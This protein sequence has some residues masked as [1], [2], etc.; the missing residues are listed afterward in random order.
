MRLSRLLASSIA[1]ASLGS[2]TSSLAQP[3]PAPSPTAPAAP[4]SAAPAAP[5]ASAP[6]APAPPAPAAPAAPAVTPPRLVE[7]A[8]AAYPEEA[9]KAGLE[10]AP[11]LLLDIDAEGKVTA[12]QVVE[13]AGHGFDEASREAALRFRFEPAR[14][15]AQPIRSRIRFRHVFVLPAAPGA[16]T[17]PIPAAGG[18]RRPDAPARGKWSGKVALHGGDEPL[19]GARVEARL[20]DGTVREARTGEDGLFRLE[21]LPAGPLAL[22]IVAPGFGEVEAQEQVQGGEAVEVVYRLRAP[23]PSGEVVV[24][25]A[26]PDREV[27]RRT[28][29]R[30]ELGLIPGTNGDALRAVQAQPG[31][32]RAPGLNAVLIVRGTRPQSTV[33]FIDGVWVPMVYHF[34]G[35]SSVVPTEALESID[36]YPGNFSARYGRAMGG[37]IEV[38]TRALAP[39]GKTSGLV[40]VDMI[41]ARA[42]A[43][44]PLPGLDGWSFLVAA[45]RSHL[46]AWLPRVLPDDVNFRQAPV[47]MDGQFFLENRWKNGSV[48]FGIFGSDDRL[49]LT[50]KDAV[51]SDPGFSAG[52]GAQ[53]GFWRMMLAY[54][55]RPAPRLKTS[56]TA[57]YGQNNESFQAGQ[58]RGKTLFNAF[59]LRGEMAYTLTPALTI[60]GGP[61]ILHY[62]YKVDLQTIA[63]PRPG[64]ADPGPLSARPQLLLRGTGSLTA[65]AAYLEADWRPVSRAKVILGGRA[66][67]LNK[68]QDLTWSPRLNARYDLAQGPRRTTIR[69]GLGLFHEMPQPVEVVEV[70]GTPSVK[71][72]RAVH[73]SVGVEQELLAGMD[74]S[75]EGFHKRLDQL[76]V[77]GTLADGSYGYTNDGTGT[78]IG[79]EALL[80]YR[81]SDRFFGWIAYTLS[82]STRSD[83]AGQ[84]EHL[85]EYDQTHN[86]TALGSV[87]LGRG[88][89]LGVRFRYVTGVPYTPCVGADLDAAAGAYACRSGAVHSAR[90]PDFH[91]LDVRLD[92]TWTFAAGRLTAYLDLMNAY[93]RQNPEALRYSYNYTRKTYDTGVPILPNLGLRGEF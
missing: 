88:F 77:R 20:A 22:R 82:R 65:P 49:A 15:G 2:A 61:D 92:K 31:V 86:L 28:M 72:N 34:G 63:P 10:G 29:D 87:S 13:P 9:R 21:D 90:L 12:A 26:R 30:R 68:N 5:S 19:A 6:A 47:Y 18:Q 40:Q 45:R 58:S 55:G 74:L 83:V 62:P 35:F 42:L 91:Q 85:L 53:Y 59:S 16:S 81:P 3:A 32:G 25:A 33:V 14:R 76:V 44:G 36:L 51:G 69:G 67:Y 93:N 60:R 66:D 8:E 57:S 17:L 48:R 73:S 41:D 24:Q 50:M 80:R 27:T 78:V 4:A 84:P 1:L 79:L 64:E 56:F 71:S 37:A 75:L 11:V 70:F 89:Q 23:R 46:D 54:E 7:Q 38:K 43:Q 39:D 52:V